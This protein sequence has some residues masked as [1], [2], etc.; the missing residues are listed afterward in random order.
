MIATMTDNR[1]IAIWPLNPEIIIYISGTMID[2]I[3][4]PSAILRLST[5]TSS[6]K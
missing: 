4:I 3:E 2:S 1:E 6:K 5:M